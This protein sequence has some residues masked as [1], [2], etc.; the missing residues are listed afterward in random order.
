MAAQRSAA[1]AAGSQGTDLMLTGRKGHPSSVIN[2]DGP[3]A[4]GAAMQNPDAR[5]STGLSF[6]SSTLHCVSGLEK[7]RD[8]MSFWSTFF[9]NSRV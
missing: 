4:A 6:G 1:R 8:Q 5:G 9:F 7:A 2:A 3:E